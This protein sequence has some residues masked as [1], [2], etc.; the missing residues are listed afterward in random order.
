MFMFDWLR[1]VFAL[2]ARFGPWVLLAAFLFLVAVVLTL[3]GLVFGF[4]LTDVDAWLEARG[5][6][7][8]AA[9]LL[10]FRIACGLVFLLCLFALVAPFL[11]RAEENG[12][13]KRGWGCALIAIPVGWFAWSGMTQPL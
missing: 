9:G 11:F 1:P 13:G 10:F 4:D 5:G 12:D 3:L 7:F 8:N 6:F 2:L